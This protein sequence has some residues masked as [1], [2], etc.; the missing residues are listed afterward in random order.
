MIRRTTGADFQGSLR[1]FSTL[2][3]SR[4]WMRPSSTYDQ[5]P[6]ADR[7]LNNAVP[8]G[9]SSS[10]FTNNI[11]NVGKW[12][13]PGGSDC[14][15]TNVNVGTNGAEI[16]AAFGGNKSTGWGRESGGDA[17]KQYVR[18]SSVSSCRVVAALKLTSAGDGQLR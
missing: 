15:I 9:L 18:W 13:G 17:W 10:L 5:S 7:R 12:L 6:N 4:L 14:G 8:Q 1:L 2:P 16:G 11:R 3:S